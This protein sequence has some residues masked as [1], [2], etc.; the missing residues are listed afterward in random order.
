MAGPPEIDGRRRA[1]LRDR[2][3]SLA[4]YYLDEWDPDAEDVGTA[5][6]ELFAEMAG[7]LT[8]R[9]D[10]APRKH[11][12]AFY[13]ALGFDRRP[14]QAATVP[15]QF[16]IDEDAPGNVPITGGTE[17]EAETDGDE[18]V[19][20]IAS[21][22]AFEATPAR[23][24][25][26]FSVDPSDDSLFEHRGAID[27]AGSST[28]F[29]G[30]DVQENVLY[31]GHPER[32]SVSAGS[33]V[34]LEIRTTHDPTALDW[35]YY[36]ESGDGDE[37][38]HEVPPLAVRWDAPRLALTP[39]GPVLETEVDGRESSWIR[40]SIPPDERSTE[41]Y[42]FEFDR[43]LVGGEENEAKPDG[44]FANDVPQ[45]TDG[46]EIY[47]F[48]SIP[49][50]RDTFYLAC[51]E[52]FA[53]PGADVTI[54]F[55]GR[56]SI[57]PEDPPRLSWEYYDGRSWRLLPGVNGNDVFH[58][59]DGEIDEASVEFTVPPD[60]DS[61]SVFG[62]DGVWIRVRLVGGE[63]V[64]VVYEHDDDDDPTES[65]RRVDGDPPSFDT[66]SIT[67]E[68][69]GSEAPTQLLAENGLEYT[70]DLVG[71]E[72]PHRP[73]EPL[74][75]D[76]QTVYFG[77]DRRLTGGP[78]QL[79]VDVEDREYPDEF[80]PR[81]RWEHRVPAGTE[82]WERLS[83]EDGTEG[84]TRPG[85]VS[86]S[87]ADD[88]EASRR[89]GV[90]RH[91]VRARVRG[92]AFEPEAAENEGQGRD[93][94]RERSSHDHTA[95]ATAGGSLEPCRS[96]LETDPGGI[97]VRPAAP[98]I[99]GVSL[100]TGV[101][102]NVTIV[103]DEVLG[104]SDGSPNL[105][106]AVSRPPAIEIEVWVDE[107]TALSSDQ[108]ERLGAERPEGLEIE[109]TTTGDVRGVW[110]RWEAVESLEGADDSDRQYVLN[111]VDGTVSFGDGTAG[112]IPPAGRENVRASYRTGGG[113]AGNVEP[114]AVVDLSTAIPHVDAV[115][116]PVEGSGGAAAES[117]AAV[118][119]RAPRELRDRDRAV[120][121]VDYER[122]AMDAARE[123]AEVRCLRGMN[124]AG[125]HEPGWV[126]VLIVPD[127]RRETPVP[128]VRLR[129]TVH[130]RVSE[131]AP[132]HLVTRDRLV[133][134]SPT[135]VSVD[136]EAT[137]VVDGVRSLGALETAIEDR[138]TAF[139]HP[140]TGKGGDGWR[141]GE[142]ATIADVIAEIEGC[143]GV[144]HVPSL[145]LRYDG[146]ETI[147]KGETP[148]E[149][150]PDV[151][152]HSGTHEL[153]VRQRTRPCVEGDR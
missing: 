58:R 109:T 103:E 148:P 118:L 36:G 110:V 79:Y 13:E 131:A 17:V 125:E 37:G 25:D 71:T 65:H 130:W 126:T 101:A 27:G 39:D 83:S 48:G 51:T 119:D 147:T 139:L 84:F 54:T 2:V 32:F 67:Y 128:S 6:V 59:E 60:I 29:T 72:G 132:L 52:A 75:D 63:Y 41:R 50:Q 68:Y 98:R 34:V 10:Q 28:L 91:W 4:P 93:E 56:D 97:E 106:L 21:E 127:E 55:G 61:T 74:P 47:P 90:E 73:F 123:L 134:R 136:V 45:P 107:M 11:Q 18:E 44:L 113:S 14:P 26:V 35:E 138:L 150:A 89:F 76:T 120:T 69:A 137:V 15:V 152:V 143:E 33:T 23:L 151:L 82:S 66:V 30:T 19:F 24:T 122:I 112:R 88:T 145:D 92:D 49:Q 94:E 78:L 99:D 114:G 115:T 121:A 64:K 146:R 9:V 141:F 104:S 96:F 117:T 22:D 133:V 20:R 124:R 53:K 12:V 80:S 8:E 70:D 95:T 111:R 57:A 3:S 38:W 135:Y 85:I 42:A 1:D 129:E 87:F 77:L 144:D 86:L 116:N 108:R 31:V 62:Q 142:L 153:V 16:S 40:G 5:L 102:A 100:N 140:L 149:V 43:L 46:T 7:G 81:V 105:A